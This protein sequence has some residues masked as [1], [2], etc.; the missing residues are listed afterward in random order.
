MRVI[1]AADTCIGRRWKAAGWGGGVLGV[2]G[3]LGGGG[4]QGMGVRFG[5]R[6]EALGVMSV[7]DIGCS[8]TFGGCAG[9][10]LSER[11]HAARVR[12]QI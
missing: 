8:A 7:G 5:L 1:A 2:I 12:L 3:G 10:C 6:V 9:A 4:V 11:V